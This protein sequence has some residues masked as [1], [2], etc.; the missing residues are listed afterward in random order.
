MLRLWAGADPHAPA[1]S[2]RYPN[3]TDGD[4]S[5]VFPADSKMNLGPCAG[6]LR[7]DRTTFL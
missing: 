5:E 1:M 2:L 3:L 7:V 6:R 4:S